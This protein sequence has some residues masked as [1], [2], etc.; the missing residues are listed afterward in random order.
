VARLRRKPGCLP[1]R[2]GRISRWVGNAA[3][4]RR[5]IRRAIQIG[6]PAL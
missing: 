2:A 1:A 4:F 5:D 6:H 3:P